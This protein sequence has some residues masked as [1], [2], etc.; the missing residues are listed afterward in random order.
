MR[1]EFFEPQFKPDCDDSVVRC[2]YCKHEY[3]PEAED[4]SEDT[5]EEECSECGKKYWLYQ[6][7]TVDHYVKPDCALNGQ[8]HQWD[9][10]SKRRPDYQSCGVCNKWRKTPAQTPD[11]PEPNPKRGSPPFPAVEAA[12][13][14]GNSPDVSHAHSANPNGGA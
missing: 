9:I 12:G 1:D 2:P 4:Y 13:G 3:Q 6:A 10:V 5:R 7:F 14:G 8:E 11:S